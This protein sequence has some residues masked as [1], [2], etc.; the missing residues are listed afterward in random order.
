MGNCGSAN[1]FKIVAAGQRFFITPVVETGRC[2]LK[3]T[4]K[5]AKK[6]LHPADTLFLG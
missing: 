1:H 5:A 2:G 4:G 3:L 6:L